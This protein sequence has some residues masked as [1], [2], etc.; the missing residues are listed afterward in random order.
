MLKDTPVIFLVSSRVGAE[1]GEIQPLRHGSLYH[2]CSYNLEKKEKNITVETHNGTK[3]TGHQKLIYEIELKASFPLW[4][5]EVRKRKL[6]QNH[7]P[8]FNMP[9]KQKHLS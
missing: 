3:S 2:F 1:S 7:T 5:L 6:E 4:K 8:G 9:Q